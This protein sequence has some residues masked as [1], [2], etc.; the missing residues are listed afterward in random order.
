MTQVLGISLPNA[1][2]STPLKHATLMLNRGSAPNYV[3][4][5]PVRAISQAA[6]QLDGIDWSRT[7]FH[8]HRGDTELKSIL[9]PSD[10]IINSTGRGT[11]GRVGFFVDPPDGSPCMAD[12]HVTIARFNRDLTEPRYS[13]YW[14]SS[15]PFQDYIF[16]ALAVGAT[17]Q[18]ELNGDRLAAA[19][20]PLPPLEEQRRIANFLDGELTRFG[21]L[22]DLQ[23]AALARLEERDSSL[24]DMTIDELLTS[25]G[26]IPFRRYIDSMD[27]G[28]SPQCDATPAGPD[29]WGVLKVSCLRPGSFYP[30]ENK[31]L[32]EDATPDVR[33]EVK[34]GDLLITRANTPQLV[35]ST[36]VV[37]ATRPRLLL[38]DKI[39][40]VRVSPN[41]DPRYVALIARGSRVRA[42]CGATSNGASQSM[43][44]V[45]FEEVKDWPIPPIELNE[46]R[47]VI[48]RMNDE[49]QRTRILHL[50]IGKQLAVLAERR[51]ALITAAVTGKID[52]SIASGRGI[53]D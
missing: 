14:L 45:R 29:E 16:A 26:A 32:P 5:G 50:K 30:D 43:A 8:N 12:G 46:Q 7:R 17:N 44:N 6:N 4:D 9:R 40:R 41:I 36:A 15:Q 24:L 37:L 47:R 33:R 20:L 13:Y 49:T 19:P 27:Q 10:V 35:G 23:R 22:A 11:L 52:V 1:W 42:L 3:D 21:K 2:S 51:Q 39:F 31:R 28:S 53:E 38:S 18:I 25:S 34:E 48:A